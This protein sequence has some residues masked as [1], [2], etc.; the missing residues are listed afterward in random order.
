[1]K[2]LDLLKKD[3]QK[4]EASFEQLSEN[5]IYAMLH[6]KSSSVVKWILIV[7]ILEFVILNGI[8]WFLPDPYQSKYNQLHPYLS[9]AENL[10]YFIILGFI[11]LFFKNYKTISVLNNA[12]L[13]IKHILKTRKIVM[14]CIVLKKKII[15]KIFH[16][17]QQEMKIYLSV[18]KM[19]LTKKLE[20]FQAS[21]NEKSLLIILFLQII[22]L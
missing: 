8:G 9:I 4:S 22:I 19:K 13:L 16:L 1:M 11:Y 10:N 7:S 20:I 17:N 2:E 14:N 21:I 18:F 6:K 15:Q 12:T 3:W 5:D